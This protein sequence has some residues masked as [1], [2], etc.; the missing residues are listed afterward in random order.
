MMNEKEYPIILV[1]LGSHGTVSE[2]RFLCIYKR[3]DGSCGRL[4]LPLHEATELIKFTKEKTSKV[5][6]VHK[7]GFLGKTTF[8]LSEIIISEN[9][10][11][12][13]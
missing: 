1:N 7:N 8:E 6:G 12:T 5:K 3:D 9:I 2:A 11:N 4:D 10:M 13:N